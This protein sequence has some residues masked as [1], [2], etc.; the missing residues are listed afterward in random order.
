MLFLNSIFIQ[1]DEL[2]CKMPQE[3]KANLTHHQSDRFNVNSRDHEK[4]RPSLF[5]NFPHTS[6]SCWYLPGQST[7]PKSF[8]NSSMS[9]DWSL[10]SISQHPHHSLSIHFMH[11]LL[12]HYFRTDRIFPGISFFSVQTVQKQLKRGELQF[13]D[14]HVRGAAATAIAVSVPWRKATAFSQE[15]LEFSCSSQQETK[16]RRRRFD[17]SGGELWMVLN[18][19]KVT[20]VL[21]FNDLHSLS[22]HILTNKLKS[23]LFKV[24]L[25]LWIHLKS[26][27]M[28]LFN[29]FHISIQFSQY[30]CG[31]FENGSP[32]PQPHSTSHLPWVVLWHVNY[33][34]VFG[35][36]IKFCRVGIF[37]SQNVASKLTHC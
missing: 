17:G 2:K 9:I 3:K 4:I 21:H 31:G 27:S 11:L 33:H 18:S 22:F 37:P 1:G 34:R 35:F 24:V 26:V 14:V 6:W 13:C 20:M 30:T 28:P 32:L 19:N 8:H 36:W 29:I 16:V 7:D 12:Q 23:I 10:A 15:A 5:P 25:Q